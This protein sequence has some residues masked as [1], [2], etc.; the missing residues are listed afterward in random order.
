MD[1]PGEPTQ[2]WL[3]SVV[4]APLKWCYVQK[5]KTSGM[6]ESNF[7]RVELCVEG[8]SAP[9]KLFVKALSAAASS[10]TRRLFVAESAALKVLGACDPRP[11]CV[12]SPFSSAEVIVM[13]DLGTKLQT[14]GTGMTQAQVESALDTLAEFHAALWGRSDT[15]ADLT[16][17]E[18]HENSL[19][20]NGTV[21]HVSL[22]YDDTERV[23]KWM[24]S[25]V[26]MACKGNGGK[27]TRALILRALDELDGKLIW[28]RLHRTPRTVLHGDCHVGNL[29][30]T[31]SDGP[32]LF[33]FGAAVYGSPAFD[34]ATVML[35]LLPRV[36]KQGGVKELQQALL[37]RYWDQLTRRL[38]DRV[39]D[40]TYDGFVSEWEVAT[41]ARAALTWRM[42]SQYMAWVPCLWMSPSLFADWLGTQKSS[43]IALTSFLDAE[44]I[45]RTAASSAMLSSANEK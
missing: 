10:V 17:L 32:V 26:R 43:V 1:Y 29:A 25:F 21:Y 41:L 38:G 37:R 42:C 12:R 3:S 27:P 39:G 5:V 8:E 40:Y 18:A 2:A 11:P 31:A 6:S 20:W 9:R 23:R 36:L 4:G 33:D 35:E 24:N 45:T 14:A 22:V 13:E 15:A 30:F 19:R 44:W 28:R 34:V 16:K 7:Y